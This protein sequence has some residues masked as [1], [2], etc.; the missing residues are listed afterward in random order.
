MNILFITPYQASAT[1][2]GTE[3]ATV[4][5]ASGL[6]KFYGCRCFSAYGEYEGSE[7]EQCFVKEAC[8]GSN[9][10]I[11]NLRKIIYDN[12]IDVVI[13][14]GEFSLVRGLRQIADEFGCTIILAHHF[15]PGWEINNVTIKQY[16]KLWRQ[17]R[18]ASKL[19]KRTIVLLLFPLIRWKAIKNFHKLY[20][21][22]YQ[23]AD[24]VVL[25]CNG[26]ID[27]FAKFG[28]IADR[29]KFH[30]I[31]NSLSFDMFFDKDK[32]NEKKHEVLIVS[33]LSDPPKKISVALKIWKEVTKHKE[34]ADWT[35]TIVGN[36]PDEELYKSIIRKEKI[37]RV[38][39]TGRKNPVPYYKNASL[40]M[41]TSISE[42][43][44]LTLTEAQQFGVVP[45]AFNTYE[46][47]TD[48]ITNN[49]S[50][51]IIPKGDIESYVRKMLFLMNNDQK[52]IQVAKEAINS[53]H[54]FENKTIS[55]RWYELIMKLKQ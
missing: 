4:S 10:R 38:L 51:F 36:G 30:I 20:Y 27:S 44:G 48:I 50:G 45:I 33:R 8:Y 26:F 49:D 16:F 40:F 29:S 18:S 22:G 5:I 1:Q 15:Q 46:S 31:P 3:R 55:A 28:R 32:L 6:S 21:E 12:S 14:Q 47:V 39:M 19:V 11:E 7:K 2:G 35:L 54:R 42:G 23:N 53:S 43:W 9:N 34:V 41:M 17:S 52:R 13:D 25:L 24:A 37:S